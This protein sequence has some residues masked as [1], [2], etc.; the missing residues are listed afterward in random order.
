[1]QEKLEISDSKI[2][3]DIS[4][5]EIITNKKLY[6]WKISVLLIWDEF[7]LQVSER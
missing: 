5:T 7:V 6:I 3:A 1:M 4:V 2:S